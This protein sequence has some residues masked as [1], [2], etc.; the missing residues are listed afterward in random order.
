MDYK[1]RKD[2]EGREVLSGLIKHLFSGCAESP[3]QKS[4]DVLTGRK[5]SFHFLPPIFSISYGVSSP[6]GVGLIFFYPFS[7]VL[8]FV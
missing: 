7:S 3:K 8:S 5:A 1:K 6:L 2:T 4:F